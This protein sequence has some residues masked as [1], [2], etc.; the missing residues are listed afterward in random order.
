MPHAVYIH[1]PFCHHICPYCDFNK[2]VLAGQPVWEY[3]E[4]LKQEMAVTF[5]RW[6]AREIRTIYVGGGT[7]TALNAEQMNFFLEAVARYVQPQA[8]NVEFTVEANPGT[9]DEELLRVMKTG[10]VNRLSFGVQTFDAKLL[11]KLGRIH[12]SEDVHQSLVLAK[13]LGFN[14]L[15]VDLMF[16][17]PGQ[18]VKMFMADVEQA[19]ALNIPHI[20]A[21]S[22]KI[23]EGTPFYRMYKHNKL[24]LPSEDEEAEMYELLIKR[25][26]EAG[27][28]HY[29][30]S[31]FAWHGY[32]SRHN[33]T[34]WRNEEYYGFGAGAHG[35]VQ[36]IRHVNAGP[37]R[38]YID[39]VTTETLPR[40]EVHPVT[41][42]EAMEEMMIM[43][44]RT[45]EGVARQTFLE[46]FGIKLE[47]QFGTQLKELQDKGLIT[48][49]GERYWLTEKGLFLGNEVFASFI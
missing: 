3:L 40:V 46:R 10:G 33:L 29:E 27:Y 35:Y 25:L 38:Q 44:L 1:I 21:Y 12:T 45:R 17:L 6:P 24:H 30:I 49:D 28:V 14:N 26:T 7:P 8:S 19:L 41:K 48:T 43:G 16:G 22:L 4:A 18:S 31:N 5:E 15:S 34:Y 36:G 9:V 32:E 13:Q 39:M 47:Q 23:E 37:V 11:K 42:Q 2:Y 20:S